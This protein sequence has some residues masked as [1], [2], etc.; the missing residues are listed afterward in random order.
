MPTVHPP[1]IALGLLI[2]AATFTRDG[3]QPVLSVKLPVA[4]ARSLTLLVDQFG[5]KILGPYPKVSPAYT[6]WRLRGL[7]LVQAIPKILDVLPPSVFRTL[8]LDWLQP[9]NIVPAGPNRT[10]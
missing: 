5:G 2:G 3:K 4:R 10:E 9:Y 1:S 7:D 8:F 6:I